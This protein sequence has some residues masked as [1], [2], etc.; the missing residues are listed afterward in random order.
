MAHMV[1][2]RRGGS[3]GEDRVEQSTK[4]E[5]TQHR[6]GEDIMVMQC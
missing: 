5:K 2:S 4:D 3:R 6:T 1:T